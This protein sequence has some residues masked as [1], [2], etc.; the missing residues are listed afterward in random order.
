MFLSALQSTSQAP[1]VVSPSVAID[2]LLQLFQMKMTQPSYQIDPDTW[3]KDVEAKRK[4]AASRP[5]SRSA[6]AVFT[7]GKKSSKEQA[8]ER[9]YEALAREIASN[10]DRTVRPIQTLLTTIGL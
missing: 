1:D 2:L 4:E 10:S 9:Q 7:Y 8:L 6:S 3:V 5:P